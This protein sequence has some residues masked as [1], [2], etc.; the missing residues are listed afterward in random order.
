MDDE[1]DLHAV[2][3]SCTATSA[4]AVSDTT[5]EG[6]DDVCHSL[7]SLASGNESSPFAFSTAG[8]VYGGLEDVY[9]AGCGLQPLSTAGETSSTD[10]IAIGI[11]GD[12]GLCDEQLPML[13]DSHSFSISSQSTRPRKRKN[14]EKRV[15][16]FTQEQLRND[17]WAW[18][19]YGQ[20]PIKGSPYPRYIF[21][22][23]IIYIFNFFY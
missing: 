16:Q 20:K 3:R 5:S 9:K 8:N 22:Y 23:L 1:W 13:T 2:V 4:A 15:F 17:L 19:K 12:Q 6:Y 14:Q 21:C 10:N 18:R 11:D 7:E